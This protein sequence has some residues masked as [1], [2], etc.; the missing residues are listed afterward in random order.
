M[1]KWRF[2]NSGEVLELSKERYYKNGSFSILN[3]TP[4]SDQDYGTLMCWGEN[5]VGAQSEPCMFQ[6]ILAGEIYDKYTVDVN[7]MQ[8]FVCLRQPF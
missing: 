2:N 6:I 4:V 7:K 8:K 1:F 3:Y 5:E